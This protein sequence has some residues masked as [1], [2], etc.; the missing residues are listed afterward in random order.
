MAI[1]TAQRTALLAV[2]LSVLG[3][4]GGDLTLPGN[5]PPSTLSAIAGNGQRGNVGAELPDP[6][7]VRVADAAGNPVANVSVRFQTS[8]PGAEVLQPGIVPTDDSGFAEAR[9]RLG[10]PEG[11]QTV[12][13]HL[14]ENSAVRTMFS[15][16]A[17]AEDPPGD[18]HGNGGG[19]DDGEGDGG[20]GGG[21]GHGD[22]GG[23]HH[24]GD[25]HHG[26]GDHHG[27]DDHH[28]GHDD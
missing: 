28:G 26:G 20:Q 7:R 14:T 2:A 4:Q 22:G 1:V 19:H 24:G 16:S 25:D 8:V 17:V 13:A 10:T 5:L 15:L 6:L 18:D 27:G 12:G 23:G 21:G 3:C 9:V 11:T